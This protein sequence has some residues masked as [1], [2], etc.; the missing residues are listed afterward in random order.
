MEC[1]PDEIFWAQ[2]IFNLLKDKA[3]SLV[4]VNLILPQNTDRFL[5]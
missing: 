1:K 4:R 3:L 2:K 5:M